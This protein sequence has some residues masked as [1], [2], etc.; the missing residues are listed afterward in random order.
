MQNANLACPDW[1]N[2]LYVSY[3]VVKGDCVDDTEVLQ[4]ILV[5]HIVAM[6]GHNIKGWM[7]LMSHEQVALVLW[8]DLVVGN[9]SVFIPGNRGQEVSRIG[10]TICSWNQLCLNNKEIQLMKWVIWCRTYF[11]VGIFRYKNW[12]TVTIVFKD[13]QLQKFPKTVSSSQKYNCKQV[14]KFEVN[15]PTLTN[16]S[17]VGQL[18]MSSKNFT[19][20]SSWW[21]INVNAKSHSLLNNTNFVWSNIQFPKLCRDVQ[22][23]SLRDNEEVPVRIV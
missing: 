21:S 16:W 10:Q 22:N 6:P 18:K 7:I 11:F 13:T 9:I 4:V 1:W 15:Y 23:T 17:K 19:N 14:S 12:G 8:N 2:T 3:H 5:R 20:V